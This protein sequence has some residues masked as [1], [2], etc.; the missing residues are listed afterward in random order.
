MKQWDTVTVLAETFGMSRSEV[1]RKLAEG[2]FYIAK[3]GWQRI[4]NK[5]D[6]CLEADGTPARAVLR[7][8]KRRMEVAILT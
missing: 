4:P 3:D 1:R 6:D 2:A 8:G 5:E 7:F